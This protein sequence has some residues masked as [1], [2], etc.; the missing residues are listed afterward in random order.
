MTDV[1]TRKRNTGKE[2]QRREKGCVREN[3]ITAAVRF[4]P[5]T[6]NPILRPDV[7]TPSSE[8]SQW[9]L[10]SGWQQQL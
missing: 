4:P 5:H 10:A 3:T 6:P 8:R 2:G 9:L 7:G 1:V